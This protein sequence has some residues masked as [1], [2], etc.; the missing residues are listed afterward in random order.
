ME[1]VHKDTFLQ[2][3]LWRKEKEILEFMV[4]HIKKSESEYITREQYYTIFNLI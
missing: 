4:G 1:L 3:F 2:F